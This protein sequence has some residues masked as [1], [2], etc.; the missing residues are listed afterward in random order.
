MLC[1]GTMTFGQDW[2]WGAD[3]V[4][5]REIFT[6]YAEHGGNLLDT[7]NNYTNGTSEAYV[8]ELISADRDYFVVGTKYSL[9]S[10]SDDPNAGGNHR[11]NKHAGR[12]ARM[13][14]VPRA[15]GPVQP[16][17]PTVS[18]ACRSTLATSTSG[19]SGGRPA[20]SSGSPHDF[21]AADYTQTMI[22][23]NTHALLRPG[24]RPW[25]NGA[26]TNAEGAPAP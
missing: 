12:A 8:G 21:L 26:T 14:R 23:G 19:V 9:S 4:A 10:R 16:C 13:D 2:G 24:D 22:H 6:R 25:R 20:S 11:K 15:A 18:A 3:K 5:S 17:P 1:L 7:A